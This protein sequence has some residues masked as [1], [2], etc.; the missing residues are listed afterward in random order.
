MSMDFAWFKFVYDFYIGIST[1]LCSLKQLG[2][3]YL[4][5][6]PF[7]ILKPWLEREIMGCRNGYGS[8]KHP[9]PASLRWGSHLPPWHDM[10]KRL[11]GSNYHPAS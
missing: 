3:V 8:L 9:Q 1:F 4:D 7:N 6:W 2:A 10:N 11:E 5:F